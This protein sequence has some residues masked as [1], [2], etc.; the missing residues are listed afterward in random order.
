[1]IPGPLLFYK[2]NKTTP[3][4]QTFVCGRYGAA[5]TNVLKR[6][7]GLGGVRPPACHQPAE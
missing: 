1:M 3:I 7:T 6:H 4:I 5:Q 2:R